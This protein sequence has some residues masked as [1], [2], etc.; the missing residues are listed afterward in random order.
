MIFF[1][2]VRFQVRFIDYG[3]CEAC[4]LDDLRK[5]NMFGNIPVLSRLYQLDNIRPLTENG[6]W[7]EQTRKYCLANVVERH[8]NLIV[9]DDL[10]ATKSH[11]EPTLCKLELFTKDKDLASAL[12]ALKLAQWIRPITNDKTA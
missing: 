10:A 4:K 9:T 8:F 2:L 12:V 11:D 1:F 5:A 3:N 7:P 6:T